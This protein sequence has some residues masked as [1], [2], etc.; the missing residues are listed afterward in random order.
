[1]PCRFTMWPK[2]S[3]HVRMLEFGESTRVCSDDGGHEVARIGQ[4]AAG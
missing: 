1:M 2:C 3:L 4:L